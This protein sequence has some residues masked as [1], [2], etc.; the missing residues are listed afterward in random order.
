MFHVLNDKTIYASLVSE[1]DE[2]WPDK[3]YK[4][5]Y[6]YLEKLPYLVRHSGC[7]PVEFFRS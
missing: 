3:D 4:M 1:L 7:P 5:A 6:E 2:L